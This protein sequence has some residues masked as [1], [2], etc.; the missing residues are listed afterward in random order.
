MPIVPIP[1]NPR[2]ASVDAHPVPGREL[3]HLAVK[4]QRRRDV[5][6]L[7]IYTQAL[8]IDFRATATEQPGHGTRARGKHK[9]PVRPTVVKR[10]DAHAVAGDEQAALGV[11][12]DREREHAVQALEATRTPLPVGLQ[13]GLRIR[14]AGPAAGG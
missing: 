2:S 8:R 1:G 5:T 7:E 9:A 4:R 12:P 11:V 3:T 10:L 13:Q 6:E 14:R